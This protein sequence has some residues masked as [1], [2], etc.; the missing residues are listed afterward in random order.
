[1]TGSGIECWSHTTSSDTYFDAF[2]FRARDSR[3]W[4]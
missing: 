4:K 1:M 2:S 3:V